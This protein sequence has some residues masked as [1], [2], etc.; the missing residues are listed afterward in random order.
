MKKILFLS[1]FLLSSCG[2]LAE[3][4]NPICAYK[5]KTFLFGDQF[6][7]AKIACT[8][9][10]KSV[11]LM[12]VSSLGENE[13]MI[14]V[15]NSPGIHGF[16]MK[17]TLIDLSIAYLDENWNVVDIKEMKSKD[18]TV[19]EPVKRALYAVE[20]NKNWFLQHNVH[21]GTNVK[22]KP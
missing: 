19:I 8:N 2:E 14:F 13:G 12:N 22:L 11:G 7:H 21:I 5:D 4:N 6:L 20:A 1:L 9:K 3:P 18:E 17:D 15:F 16:W 10:D